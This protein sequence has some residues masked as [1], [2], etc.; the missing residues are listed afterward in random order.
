MNL[1]HFI[2]VEKNIRK[3][4]RSS[5]I[6]HIYS[7]FRDDKFYYYVMEWAKGGDLYTLI[8]SESVR[9]QMFRVKGEKAIRFILGCII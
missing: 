4:V 1:E 6:T 7:C 8:Q 9:P 3:M 2:D 5:F